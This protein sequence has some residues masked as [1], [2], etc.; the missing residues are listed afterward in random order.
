MLQIIPLHLFWN[1]EIEEELLGTKL[2]D[3]NLSTHGG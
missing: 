3:V 2:L 1:K